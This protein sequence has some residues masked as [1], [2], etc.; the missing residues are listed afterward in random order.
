MGNTL[1]ELQDV[2][3]ALI[4][5]KKAIEIN[6]AFADAHCN[7]ASIYKDMGSITEA[8]EFYK[9]ALK[10]KSDFPDAYCNLAHCLQIVC[11]WDDYVERMH[12]IVSIVEDQLSTEN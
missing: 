8:I 4:C 9:N 2:T 11:N 10:F 7:L 3:G 5:F 6:P 12:N 1:R